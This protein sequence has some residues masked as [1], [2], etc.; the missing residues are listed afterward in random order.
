MNMS[1]IAF[2]TL[3]LLGLGLVLL[4]TVSAQNPEFKSGA[5][6]NIGVPVD[7]NVLAQ[8]AGAIYDVVESDDKHVVWKFKGTTNDWAFVFGDGRIVI[9]STVDFNLDTRD[10]LENEL[11]K[12]MDLINTVEGG[13]SEDAKWNAQKHAV[14]YA[15]DPGIYH[16]IIWDFKGNFDYTL[17]VP[18]CTIKEA[19]M[20]VYSP[21][22]PQAYYQ[23]YYI[24]GHEIISC[25]SPG[26]IVPSAEITDKI[27]TGEHSLAG[28]HIESSH[29]MRVE[30]ITS[31]SPLKHFV[32][33]GP[34][35]Q[36]WINETS[37]SE[38]LQALQ[39][40]LYR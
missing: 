14:Y 9:A 20:I 13:I 10:T 1:K 12:V 21:D 26:C 2:V 16:S 31:P 23:G 5:S 35:Y 15:T 22:D 25:D 11:G 18:D 34:K 28:T 37:T 33:Y 8:R 6:A 29:I 17:A 24:D 19:K 3:A 38:D 27:T 36:P 30:A 39:E 32:L 40:I 4:G 7:F